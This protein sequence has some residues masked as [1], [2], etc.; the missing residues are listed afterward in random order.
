[1]K[2]PFPLGILAVV[3]TLTVSAVA[4]PSAPSGDTDSMLFL[5]QTYC[6]QMDWCPAFAFYGPMTTPTGYVELIEPDGTP[7]DYL[8]VEQG[9]LTFESSPLNVPPPG[10][11]PLLGK[12]VEDGTLQE[13]DQFFPAGRSRP[14]FMQSGTGSA[15]NSGITGEWTSDSRTFD[16]VVVRCR[17]GTRV[18]ARAAV[19][20][21]LTPLPL[22]PALTK[23]YAIVCPNSG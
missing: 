9:Y 14:L 8:W 6:L 15:T 23:G 3:L 16:L 17:D 11:L 21:R 13:V 12:L 2:A 18:S 4:S 5:G 20:A 1:M 22:L 19:L 10:G 7:S